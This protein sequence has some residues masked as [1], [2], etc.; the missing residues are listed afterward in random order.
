MFDKFMPEYDVLYEDGWESISVSSKEDIENLLTVDGEKVQSGFFVSVLTPHSTIT[1]VALYLNLDGDNIFLFRDYTWSTLISKNNLP[2]FKVV[3]ILGS[4]GDIK[5]NPNAEK[6]I[7]K[8]HIENISTSLPHIHKENVDYVIANSLPLYD[9]YL[10]NNRQREDQ[11]IKELFNRFSEAL[12]RQ[13]YAFST[14]SIKEDNV[15][16]FLTIMTSIGFY[17]YFDKEQRLVVLG[18]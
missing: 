15:Y 18:N 9:K 6:E 14:V 16:K 4:V 3:K 7:S 2:N 8:E 11:D 12:N 10:E 5:Q 1:D 13:D 17:L